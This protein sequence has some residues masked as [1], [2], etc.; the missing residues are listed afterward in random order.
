MCFL[1]TGMSMQNFFNFSRINIFST[2]DDH[3]FDSTNNF[4][5]AILIQSANV[6]ANKKR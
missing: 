5:V 3:V 6:P 4:D 2:A 1:N